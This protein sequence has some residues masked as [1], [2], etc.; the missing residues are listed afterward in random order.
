MDNFLLDGSYSYYMET[1]FKNLKEDKEYISL[2]ENMYKN[3]YV[4]KMVDILQNVINGYVKKSSIT[5]NGY[6][7][8]NLNDKKL[9][10]LF[11]SLEDC[12]N[13]AFNLK[14]NIKI[15]TEYPNKIGF[16]ACIFVNE[17]DYNEA[18]NNEIEKI[19]KE[20][21][22]GLSFVKI[23]KCEIWIQ[24]YLFKFIVKNNL[25]ARHIVAVLLHEIGHKL[26]LK[27]NTKIEG[28]HTIISLILAGMEVSIP[29]IITSATIL[30][31]TP[32]LFL[33]N[34]PLGILFASGNILNSVNSYS[35]TEGN[36][37]YN[38]IT[39]GFGK[40]IYELFVYFES[41]SRGYILTKK[42]F[43][44]KLF[45]TDYK[46]RDIM[47]NNIVKEINN[48]NNTELERKKLKETLKYI[49]KLIDENKKKVGD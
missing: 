1:K 23:N 47:Y 19:I 3:P 18:M 37:D 36:C 43:I 41:S 42:N 12:M 15:S 17:D 6:Q 48:P 2:M 13:K 22:T 38:A 44:R 11:K 4:D 35:N 25:N 21:K 20:N 27:L 14:S 30:G 32:W 24:E 26:Y 40:E 5:A 28:K 39:Y 16:G 46:R 45:S 10:S 9:I 29:I 34:I 31:A 33:L 8:F 7:N 49:D